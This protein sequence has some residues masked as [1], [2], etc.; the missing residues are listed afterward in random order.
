MKLVNN[1]D[2]VVKQMRKNIGEALDA[3]GN[4][5][6]VSMQYMMLYGYSRPYKHRH[7]GITDTKI[8]DTGA[9]YKDLKYLVGGQMPGEEDTV[10]FGSS[11]YYAEYV[12]EGTRKVQARPYIEDAATT[13]ADFKGVAEKEL[14][15][16]FDKIGQV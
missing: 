16:G 3:I 5:A 6:I 1:M 7:T 15:R 10:H 4:E 13:I 11:L 12:H 8:Y 9:L 2:K 14:K